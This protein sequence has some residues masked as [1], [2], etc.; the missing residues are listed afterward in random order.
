MNHLEKDTNGHA[1]MFRVMTV[2]K[3]IVYLS[4]DNCIKVAILEVPKL[5]TSE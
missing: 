5:L 2:T 4:S 1:N 3:R